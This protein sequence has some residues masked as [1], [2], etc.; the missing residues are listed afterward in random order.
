[1]IHEYVVIA[2]FVLLGVYLVSELIFGGGTNKG[3]HTGPHKMKWH[4]GKWYPPS[5]GT[6]DGP[7]PAPRPRQSAPR[8]PELVE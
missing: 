6:D 5:S 4:R 3:T 8:K 2:V 1:M 7:D